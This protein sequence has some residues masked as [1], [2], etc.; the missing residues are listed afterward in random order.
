M[1]RILVVEDDEEL[2]DIYGALLSQ[3]GYSNMVFA[4]DGREAVDIYNNNDL[5]HLPDIVIMDYKMPNKNGLMTA[6]EILQIDPDAVIV[7]VS[8]YDAVCDDAVKL[9]A[10]MFSVKPVTKDVMEEMLRLAVKARADR[11]RSRNESKTVSIQE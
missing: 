11:I 6:Q 7:F 2:A 1:T 4:R 3:L 9:G 5:K 10:L 8:G